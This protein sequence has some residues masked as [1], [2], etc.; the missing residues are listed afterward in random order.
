MKS[1]TILFFLLVFL[2]VCKNEI[3]AQDQNIKYRQLLQKYFTETNVDNIKTFLIAQKQNLSE[4][5]LLNKLKNPALSTV[6]EKNVYLDML[7][8]NASRRATDIYNVKT[9]LSSVQIYVPEQYT[10]AKSPTSGQFV[11]TEYEDF[12]DF[13]GFGWHTLDKYSYDNNLNTIQWVNQNY[14][15]TA[16]WINS[17]LMMYSYDSFN[18]DTL[19]VNQGWD[20]GSLS[21]VNYGKWATTY[22]ASNNPLNTLYYYWTD[23]AWGLGWRYL[24]TYDANNNTLEV[25]NQNWE[26]PDWVNSSRETYTYDTNNNLL[27]DISFNW[28]GTDWQEIFKTENTYDANNNIISYTFSF[29]GTNSSQD[30]Y[31]Y[32]NN[33]NQ[34]SDSNYNWD[35]NSSSWVINFVLTNTYD[36][37]NNQ[38]HY[39]V[40]QSNGSTLVDYLQY[41]ATFNA[42]NY[43]TTWR[44]YTRDAGNWVPRRKAEYSYDADQNITLVTDSSSSNGGLT[45]RL[46]SRQA[47]TWSQGVTGV[48]NEFNSV[49]DY[50][51][52]QNYPNPFN[53]ST[54]INFSIPNKANVSLK[55]FDLLGSQIAELVNGEIEAGSYEVSFDASKLV[56]GVYFYKIQSENFSE[57]KKMI[58]LK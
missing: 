57:T 10:M 44:S 54:S 2:F 7:K 1:Y 14:D 51:L 4:T 47:Y 3:I 48:E 23:P 52:S 50:R 30:I 36:A 43:I 40:K 19:E 49:S 35:S 42:F 39:L 21:W 58:L 33:N 34:I 45:W 5:D 28:T 15:S 24:Y 13:G 55:V 31:T 46:F 32:D 37:N 17:S 16:G 29:F 11:L 12:L 25:L 53:P 9:K 41:D 8:A 22:D 6:T 56:S 27:V 38:I 18:R 26:D 20:P